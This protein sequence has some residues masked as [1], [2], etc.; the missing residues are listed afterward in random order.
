MTLPLPSSNLLFNLLLQEP[1]PPISCKTN[2]PRTEKEH[3]G[4]FGD[5]VRVTL[6]LGRISCIPYG[7]IEI[8]GRVKRATIP[9]LKKR[10]S[11]RIGTEDGRNAG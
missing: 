1:L 8:L 11:G 2:Q 7:G 9:F 5:R 6:E 4:G 3:G 10:E